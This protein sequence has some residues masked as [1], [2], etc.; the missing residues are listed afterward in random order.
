MTFYWGCG[1]EV[2]REAKRHN[3]PLTLAH[4]R[5]AYCIICIQYAYSRHTKILASN[6]MQNTNSYAYYA[7]SQHIYIYIYAQY[8][9]SSYCITSSMHSINIIMHIMH[10][11]LVI[12]WIL[13]YAY[14]AQYAYVNILQ[15]LRVVSIPTI[16]VCTVYAHTVRSAL[17]G[18]MRYLQISV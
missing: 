8:D 18:G 12:L 16:Y 7:H 13:Q 1:V 11:L 3:V 6:I 10:T 17:P 15:Y 2:P 5:T 14:Y 4:L 9:T